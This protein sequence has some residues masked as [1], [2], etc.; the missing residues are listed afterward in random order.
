M[1]S[2]LLNKGSHEEE[3][4][5]NLRLASREFPQAKVAL[6]RFYERSGQKDAAVREL[7]EFLPQ[8]SGAERVT[9]EQ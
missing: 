3:A 2:I 6:A 5:E 9:V 8:A 1:G 4:V 7:R